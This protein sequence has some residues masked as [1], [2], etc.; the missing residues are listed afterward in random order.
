MTFTTVDGMP[1]VEQTVSYSCGAISKRTYQGGILV[2]CQ[3]ISPIKAIQRVSPHL[4]IEHREVSLLNF[5]YPK[6]G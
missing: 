6:K 2:D 5:H 1:A 3:W 4:V